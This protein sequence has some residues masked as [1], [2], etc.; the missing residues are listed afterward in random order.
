MHANPTRHGSVLNAL[1]AL[2]GQGSAP[3]ATADWVVWALAA[4]VAMTIAY[5]GMRILMAVLTQMRDGLFT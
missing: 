1:D 2:A 5:G 3:V 4:P